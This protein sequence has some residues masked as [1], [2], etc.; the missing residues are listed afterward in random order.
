MKKLLIVLVMV[1]LASFS[2][3]G[4]WSDGVYFADEDSFGS[5]GWKY[6]VVVTVKNGKISKAIWNG[7]NINGGS[8]KITASKA[9]KYGMVKN[10]GAQDPWYVQAEKVQKY[11]LKTQDPKKITYKDDQGHTDAIAGASIHVIEFFTLADKALSSA[12]VKKGPYKDGFPMAEEASFSKSSGWKYFA[13]FT[14]VNGTVVQ[15]NWNG[16]YKNGG[17]SK[18]IVSKNGDYGMKKNGGSISEWH[19]QGALAEKYFLENQG[20]APKSSDNYHTDAITGATMGV[21][22]LWTLADKAL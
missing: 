12:P 22:P 1:L 14:V 16:T 6:H 4:D 10:G 7:T 20:K 17:D 2:F 9:G 15:V 3:A 8:D 21:M 18:K 13:Q 19:V 5:S 11:L